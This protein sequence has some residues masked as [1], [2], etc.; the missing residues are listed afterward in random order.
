MNSKLVGGFSPAH[1]KN[2]RQKRE[3]SPRIGVNIEII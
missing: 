3:S 2:I 1:L